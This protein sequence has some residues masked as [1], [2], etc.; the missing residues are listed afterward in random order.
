MRWRP[1]PSW[2]PAN[3]FAEGKCAALEAGMNGHIGKPIGIPKLIE[4][5]KKILHK[6]WQAPAIGVCRFCLEPPSG[7]EVPRRGGERDK[8][9]SCCGYETFSLTRFAGPLTQPGPSVA[10]REPKSDYNFISC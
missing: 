5:L 10:Q 8:N 2:P 1:S 4:T 9:F 7:R 3:A 6:K